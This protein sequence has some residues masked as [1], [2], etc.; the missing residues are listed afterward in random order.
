MLQGVLH[1][2]TG[3]SKRA[4]LRARSGSTALHHKTLVEAHQI[5]HQTVVQQ[6]VANGH[7]TGIVAGLVKQ[8]IEQ[9][10]IHQNVAVIGDKQVVLIR[11]QM[12][13]S[14]YRQSINGAIDDGFK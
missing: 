14:T 11:T 9:A 7:P 13:Q 6:I 12:L 10:R 5:R 3:S 1:V 2:A 4:V 8:I